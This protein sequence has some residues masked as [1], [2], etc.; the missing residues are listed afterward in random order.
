MPT[1][2]EM[3]RAFLEKIQEEP[4]EAIHR[5][6]YADWLTDHGHDD[7]SLVHREWTIEA[8]E[9]AL[10]YLEKYAR[11]CG[12]RREWGETDDD[13]DYSYNAVTP[14]TLLREA[15]EF[16]ESGEG[17]VIGRDTPQIAYG[18]QTEFWEAFMTVTGI[19]VPVE[20]RGRRF[21]RCSC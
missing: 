13:G 12:F 11:E 6:V 19:F 7:E 18:D 21:V 1:E 15:R 10:A 3:R 5:H 8:Y 2:S 14:A 16:L 17:M 20:R 4:A 9:E